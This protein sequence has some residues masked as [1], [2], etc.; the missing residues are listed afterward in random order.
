MEKPIENRLLITEIFYSLQGETS[1]AGLPFVFVRLTG[2][3]LRC[4]YCDTTYAFKST[5]RSKDLFTIEEIIERIRSFPTQNILL[6]GGEPLLQRPT[7]EL[8]RRLLERGYRV[9]IETHGELSIASLP[10][11]VR[12]V[13]DIKTPS[14]GMNRGGYEKNLPLLKEKDEV[15]FVIASPS[16]YSWARDLVTNH[17]LL[18]SFPQSQILFSP[19]LKHLK[20]PGSYEGVEIQWLAEQILK[21][22]LQVRFQ[23][24]LHKLI[25]D[26]DARGV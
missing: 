21:D 19:A 2:C 23:Y 22:N 18:R 25:W 10:K 26:R 13:L 9:S 8:A 24:Q 20:T 15:K 3:N 6:T 5:N 11:E 1:Q 14:S 7:P 12:V 17:P 4:T 16:D